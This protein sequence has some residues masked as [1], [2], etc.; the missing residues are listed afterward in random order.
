[1][2]TF[3][4]SML[5]HEGGNLSIL[6]LTDISPLG[7]WPPQK[8]VNSLGSSKTCPNERRWNVDQVSSLWISTAFS[9]RTQ[10]IMLCAVVD[11]GRL[12]HLCLALAKW[13]CVL[14]LFV[15]ID[16]AHETMWVG[17]KEACFI[18]YTYH[19]VSHI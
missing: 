8:A 10:G 6:C 9:I 11:F 18:T 3:L 12:L 7:E 5:G 17:C 19:S 16:F 13:H 2:L 4:L 1:M 15:H 14:P